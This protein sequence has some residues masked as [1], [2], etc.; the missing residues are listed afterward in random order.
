MSLTSAAMSATT[1]SNQVCLPPSCAL[2][3]RRSVTVVTKFQEGVVDRRAVIAR[4][5]GVLSPRQ[6]RHLSDFFGA[7]LS[8]TVPAL[9]TVLRRELAIAAQVHAD[10]D[11]AGDERPAELPG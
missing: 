11:V 6:S 5:R 4:D 9:G 10:G 3:V 8:E 2:H 7:W 1:H